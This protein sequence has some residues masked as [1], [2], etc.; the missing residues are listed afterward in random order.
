MLARRNA[1]EISDRRCHSDVDQLIEVLD[2]VSGAVKPAADERSDASSART[3][4]TSPQPREQESVVRLY[5]YRPTD[6]REDLAAGQEELR[7]LRGGA[8][9]D[10]RWYVR[11]ASRRSREPNFANWDFGFRVVMRPAS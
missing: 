3:A 8:F 5:P 11:C 6:G 2:R 1:I 4:P 7:V 10:P 9:R